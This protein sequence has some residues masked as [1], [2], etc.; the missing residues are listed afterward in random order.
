MNTT[1]RL[2]RAREHAKGT[3]TIIQDS[4]ALD[5]LPDDVRETFRVLVAE[6]V[7]EL[8]TIEERIS[9][10]IYFAEQHLAEPRGEE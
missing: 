4:L 5:T 3:R 9:S 1:T 2:T 6:L 8:I 7:V 10:A